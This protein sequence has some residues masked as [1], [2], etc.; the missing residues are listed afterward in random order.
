MPFASLDPLATIV[1]MLASHLAGANALAVDDRNAGEL[2]TTSLLATPKIEPPHHATIPP[3]H[4]IFVDRTPRRKLVREQ[5][6]MTPLRQN[7]RAENSHQVVR[8]RE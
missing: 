2:L 3:C 7:N 1:T 5:P 4:E 8:R 6:P